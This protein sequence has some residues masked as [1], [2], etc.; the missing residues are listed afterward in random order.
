MNFWNG[1]GLWAEW[2]TG[3]ATD[4]EAQRPL[5]LQL[6]PHSRLRVLL[7]LVTIVVLGLFLLLFVRSFGRWVRYY[8]DA[9]DRRRERHRATTPVRADDWAE[10][11]LRRENE[12]DDES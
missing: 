10:H 7:A 11:P 9:L 6:S 1:L 2:V 12:D 4:V 8:A 5:W 3:V